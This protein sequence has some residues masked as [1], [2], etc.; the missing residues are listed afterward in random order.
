MLNYTG[1]TPG[2]HYFFRDCKLQFVMNKNL[3]S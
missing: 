2:K 3:V 1:I